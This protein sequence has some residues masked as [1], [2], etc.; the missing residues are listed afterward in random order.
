MRWTFVALVLPL[1]A[2][3]TTTSTPPDAGGPLDGLFARYPP[4]V[5]PWA[6]RADAVQSTGIVVEG[7]TFDRELIGTAAALP[8]RAV[9]VFPPADSNGF[10][11][12]WAGLD[13]PWQRLDVPDLTFADTAVI[14]AEADETGAVHLAARTLNPR[15]LDYFVW[16]DGAFVSHE[17]LLLQPSTEPSWR[18]R[19]RDLRVGVAPD[20]TVDLVYRE[21]G[22]K[23]MNARRARGQRAF[24]TTVALAGGLT[25]GI[26]ED[27]GC[28]NRITYDESGRPVVTTL[29]ELRPLSEGT[30]RA[31]Q[32]PKDLRTALLDGRGRWLREGPRINGPSLKLD[33]YDWR[34]DFDLARTSE[35]VVVLAGIGDG[36]FIRAVTWPTRVAPFELSYRHNGKSIAPPVGWGGVLTRNPC[37]GLSIAS[38]VPGAMAMM[39]SEPKD[40]ETPGRQADFID[41]NGG[42]RCGAAREA[43]LVRKPAEPVLFASSLLGSHG[44]HS[45]YSMLLCAT[46]YGVLAVCKGT[47]GAAMSMWGIDSYPS[48]PGAQVNVARVRSSTPPNGARDVPVDLPRLVLETDVQGTV[49]WNVTDPNGLA[50]PTMRSQSGGTVTLTL[51]SPLEAG[52]TYRVAPEGAAPVAHDQPEPVVTFTTAGE[53]YGPA[54]VPIEFTFRCVPPNLKQADGTCAYPEQQLANDARGFIDLSF[55]EPLADPLPHPVELV[56]GAG[57]LRV[58]PTMN[59][60]TTAQGMGVLRM[61]W[62]VPLQ[63]ETTYTVT[64][65]KTN[66]SAWNEF[67]TADAV[68]TFTTPPR[69]IELT[70]ATPAAASVVAIDTPVRLTF[71]KPPT[72]LLDVSR[73]TSLTV[74]PS[75][76]TVP[77]SWVA[78]SATVFRGDHAAWLADTEYVLSVDPISDARG[79]QSMA[80][81]NRFRT[82]P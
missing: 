13:A 63:L 67:L 52:R 74:L 5:L 10:V 46:D 66:P 68:L 80:V 58:V 42:A 32:H 78:E 43:P 56:A 26:A 45:P 35:G 60:V 28:R 15:K 11:I 8:D 25:N 48:P 59:T 73:R 79:S 64:F 23:V 9:V 4:R 61:K 77:L 50:V 36:D 55:T 47:I 6:L 29:S 3:P 76:S 75:G 51:M 2:C 54:P 7:E 39:A 71:S 34:G 33:G 82:A 62:L 27:F 40:R 21:D 53:R 24:A 49:E 30:S 37:G 19:C 1:L 41:L 20:G 72:S 81:T 18:L 16:K 38:N 14:D 17:Q 31:Y 22:R 65:P 70:S 12:A 69:P 57:A 44:L